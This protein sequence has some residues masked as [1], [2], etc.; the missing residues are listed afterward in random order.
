MSFLFNPNIPACPV[1]SLKTAQ[2][3]LADFDLHLIEDISDLSLRDSEILRNLKAHGAG[4]LPVFGL[5][6]N[7]F[8]YFLAIHTQLLPIGPLTPAYRQAG[9]PS[10]TRG[11][12]GG[13]GDFSFLLFP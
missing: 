7:S 4:N 12:G 13:E 8:F 6:F 10:P 11:E 1:Q 5:F 2:L 9:F 3:A